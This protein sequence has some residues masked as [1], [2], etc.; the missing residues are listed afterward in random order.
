MPTPKDDEAAPVSI[1]EPAPSP[2]A[3]EPE[4]K[5]KAVVVV[6]SVSPIPSADIVIVVEAAT[7]K[8]PEGA[9]KDAPATERHVKKTGYPTGAD[10]YLR[11]DTE[12]KFPADAAEVLTMGVDLSQLNFRGFTR[13]LGMINVGPASPAYAGAN[14]AY[15]R[16]ATDIRIVGL[17]DDEVAR[18]KPY[19]DE[20]P[21]L[22]ADAAEVSVS[23]G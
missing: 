16:G 12:V 20:L 23:F 15:Q 13:Q 10:T 22:T 2:V 1:P 3:P 14:L 4:Q 6:G 21:Y 19:V 11:Y 5:K 18:L 8:R 9:E 7:F 17:T